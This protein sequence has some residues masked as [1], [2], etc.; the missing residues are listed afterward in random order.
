MAM[1]T[2]LTLI[3]SIGLC[4]DPDSALALIVAVVHILNFEFVFISCI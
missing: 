3:H 4:A 1:T 2:C